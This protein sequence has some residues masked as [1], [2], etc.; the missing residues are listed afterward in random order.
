MPKLELYYFPACPFCQR[1]LTTIDRLQ[2]KVVFKDIR[3]NEEYLNQLLK[4]TGKKTV[5]CLYIDGKPMFESSD[6][7]KWLEDHQAQLEKA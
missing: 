3:E 7:M 4:D 5:P 1:V 2:V 6:I